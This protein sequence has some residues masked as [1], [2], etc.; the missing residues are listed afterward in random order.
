[1]LLLLVGNADPTALQRHRSDF[2]VVAAAEVTPL[3]RTERARLAQLVI[4]GFLVLVGSG[5]VDVVH[6][7]LGAAVLVLLL[8]I[9]TPG[10]ARSSLDLDVLVTLCASFGLGEAVKSSGLGVYLA[11]HLVDACQVVGDAG[12]LLGVLL[13]TAIVTQVVTNNAA[14]IVMFPIAVSTAAAAHHDPRIFVIAVILGSSM[15]YLTTF[16]YQTNL[17]VAGLAGYR[18]R[19]FL[20]L[21]SALLLLSLV[22]SG[23][24]LSWQ[25]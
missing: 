15:S 14:A 9:I 8:R 1:V 20:P 10:Q 23:A 22:V 6:A 4:L 5:F 3:V 2:L 19:D 25:L 7:A 11:R 17:M 12:P 18:A 24:L 13:A 21:G 16:G